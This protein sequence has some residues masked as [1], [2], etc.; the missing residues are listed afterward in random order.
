MEIFLISDLR[1]INYI[2]SDLFTSTVIERSTLVINRISSNTAK[3][4]H[5]ISDKYILFCHSTTTPQP[6]IFFQPPISLTPH[7]LLP[8][9]GDVPLL[10]SPHPPL[11]TMLLC[12]H[13]SQEFTNLTAHLNRGCQYAK[14]QPD[15]KRKHSTKDSS[16]RSRSNVIRQRKSTKAIEAL[17][18]SD[19][20]NAQKNITSDQ[21]SLI[22]SIRNR[23][24]KKTQP[25]FNIPPNK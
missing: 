20:H 13:C 9:S 14:S 12:P 3:Y 19:T 1:Y 4:S 18:T 23:A 10:L 8:I 5:H 24:N 21:L 2:W 6:V 7:T 25:R 11:T 17:L 16:K 22:P 15:T